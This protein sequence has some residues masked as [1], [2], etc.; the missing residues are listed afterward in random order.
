[1][2]L[3]FKMK[4]FEKIKIFITYIVLDTK[5]T[6]PIVYISAIPSALFNWQLMISGPE[7]KKVHKVFPG[8]RTKIF[9]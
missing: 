1:M 6:F 4:A 3:S 9:F 8:E 7:F 2:V 5:T